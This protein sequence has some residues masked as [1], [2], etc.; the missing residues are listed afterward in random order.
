M[1]AAALLCSTLIL[2]V[3]CKVYYT[4]TLLAPVTWAQRKG[5]LFVT[6][7]LP[8]VE[9]DTASITL[10]DERLTFAGRSQGNDYSLELE[11]LKSNG[12]IDSSAE[13][14][15]YVI[16]PRHVQFILVKKEEG[17][18]LR[19]LEDKQ[20]QKTNVRVD[21]SR[22]IDSDEEETAKEFDSAGMND[23]AGGM[24]MVSLCEKNLKYEYSHFVF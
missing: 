7:E 6:I 3:I 1:S 10:T 5:E 4:M 15:K 24:G 13:G 16:K 18:W 17:F 22:Y 2:E 14:S 9:K 19:L 12:G 20:L 21:F 11:W 8:D 23:L